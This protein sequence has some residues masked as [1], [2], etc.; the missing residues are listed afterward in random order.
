VGC[1]LAA[2]QATQE[3]L[4]PEEERDVP[5]ERRF[6]QEPYVIAIISQNMAFFIVTAKNLKFYIEFTGWAL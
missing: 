5:R 6:L 4:D 2:D 3:S 1:I